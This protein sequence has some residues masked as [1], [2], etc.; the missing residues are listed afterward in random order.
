MNTFTGDPYREDNGADGWPGSAIVGSYSPN[1]FGLYD[2]TG[3]VW[4]WVNDY[5]TPRPK[6][7]PPGKRLKNPQGPKVGKDRTMKGGSLMCH[8]ETCRR[9]R[10]SG[11][12]HAEPDSSTGNMGFRCA[13]DISSGKDEL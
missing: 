2:M 3:N 10:C 6:I 4:E 9:Y 8:K 11:R 13:Y 7:P 1:N 5:W 12:T